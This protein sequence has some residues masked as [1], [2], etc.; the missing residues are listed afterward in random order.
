MSHRMTIAEKILAR[1]AGRDRV[2]P[3]EYVT[4][5]IDAAMMPDSFRLLRKV[6]QRPE[7]ASRNFISGTRSASWW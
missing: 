1:A 5:R 6:L 4:A 3:G 7:S 2:R